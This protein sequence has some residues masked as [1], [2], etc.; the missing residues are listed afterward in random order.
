MTVQEA[1]AERK[2]AKGEDGVLSALLDQSYAIDEVKKAAAELKEVRRLE[3]KQEKR[4]VSLGAEETR[5]RKCHPSKKATAL[6]PSDESE[7]RTAKLRAR[8]Q[9]D[10][11][12]GKR[13]DLTPAKRKYLEEFL[14]LEASQGA[15]RLG[16]PFWD[17]ISKETAVSVHNLKTLITEEGR[18]ITKSRA[19]IK[20]RG[21][22]R[23][24]RHIV[25]HRSQGQRAMRPDK[26]GGE[27]R[28]EKDK[29]RAWLKKEE[30]RGHEPEAADLLDQFQLELEDFVF[31]CE[32]EEKQWKEWEEKL[33]EDELKE[34]AV[35]ITEGRNKLK[36]ARSILAKG[37]SSK[38]NRAYHQQQLLLWC[39]KVRRKP[40]LVFPMTEVEASSKQK[41]R[42]CKPER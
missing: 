19:L 3:A 33:T 28:E 7:E 29:V 23:Y 14:D 20:K 11:H 35:E 26:L 42:E 34:K 6:L 1:E 12:F 16:K 38:Q 4:L 31:H 41:E 5:G 32:K 30:S 15:H 18:K 17:R 22:G 24:W 21:K 36:A 25:S 40:D 9:R 2:R 8:L 10:K 39:E 37:F 27:V 13:E